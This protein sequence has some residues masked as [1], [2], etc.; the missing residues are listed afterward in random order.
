MGEYKIPLEEV[1]KFLIGHD[2]EKYIVNIEYEH[3]TNLI[4]KFK[5]L[6]DG[7][8]TT[9]TEPLRAFLW[10]KSL[11]ELKEKV[12]F[13]GGNSLTIRN[14]REKYGITI[15]S[16]EHGNHPR[17]ENGY[18]YLLTCDQGYDRMMEFFKK[19]GFYRGLYDKTHGIKDHF[20]ILSPIE[21]YLV[22][23]GKRLFKGYDDYNDIEKFVF[24]LETTGLDPE[25]SRIFAIGCKTN[26]GFE[27]L[28][29][30]EIEGDNADKTEVAAIAKFFTAIDIVKPAIIGGY[31]SANFDWPF[32]F[33]RCEKLGIDIESLAKTRKSDSQIANKDQ[34]LK[35]GNEVENYTQTN[36][37]GYSI[38]DVIHASRKAQAID[39]NMKGVGLKYVCK[40]NKIAK[41]NRVYIKGDK[42]GWY[43]K[44]TNKFYFDNKTGT[45]CETKPAFKYQ[46][47]ITLEDIESNQ[48]NYYVFCVSEKRTNDF[49]IA[50]EVNS[51]GIPIK[52]HDQS[53]Y[54]DDDFDA[55]KKKINRVIKLIINKI[56]AGKTIVLP[57]IFNT[58]VSDALKIRAPKTYSF[59]IT[60]IKALESYINTYIECD[61]KYIVRRYLMDDLWETAEIDNVYNQSSFLLA[62]LIPT[63]FQRVSTMGTAGLWKMIMLTWSYEKNLAIPLPDEKRDFVGGLSRL[64]KVGFSKLLRKADYNSLY[65][66]IQ[67]SSDLFPD[68]DITGVLKSFLKYFHSERF[69][70]KSLAKK[71]KKAGDYQME[72]LYK[73]KQLPLKIFINSLYGALTAPNAFPWAQMDKGEQVTCSARQYLRLMTKFFMGRGYTPT[74]MDSVTFDTPVYIK[75]DD[76]KIDIKA[77]SELFNENSDFLDDE[78]L[79][80]FS[81]KNFKVLTRSGWKEIKYVYRH[82]TDKQI[83][84]LTTKDRYI[85]VTEDHSLFNNGVEVKPIDLEKGSHIDIYN[86]PT[87]SEPNDITPNKAWL[88]GFFLGDGSSNNNIRKKANKYFSKRKKQY[89]YYTTRRYDWKISNKDTTLLTKLQSILKDEFGISANIKDHLKSSGVYNLYTSKKDIGEF[90]S[91]HFYTEYREKKVPL[92]ILNA[93]KEIKKSFIDGFFSADGNGYTLEENTS[94]C[95]KSQVC[96]AGLALILNELGEDFKVMVRP[97]KENIIRFDTGYFRFNAVHKNKPNMSPKKSDEIW[98]K[99]VI[100]NKDKNNYVYDISTEDGT[101]IAGING[102]IAHNTDGINFMA[103]KEGEEHFKYVGKG[104][105]SEVEEGKLYTGIHAV[106]AE[107]NDLYME[108][109]MALGLDGM[110]PSTINLARKNYA[111]LEEDGTISLT[112]NTIKSKKMSAYVE[113]FLD[114]A[115]LLLLNDKGYEFV[116][117]YYSYVDMIY[118]KQIPLSKIATKARVKKT[119]DAYKNRGLNKNGK[120][121]PKQAHMELAIENN[122]H[123]N[124]GDTIYYVNVGTK[125]SHTDVRL[126][127]EGKMLSRLIDNDIIENKPDLLGDYNV[128]RYLAMFNSRIKGLLVVFDPDVRKKILISSP[129]KKIEWL[130]SELDLCNGKPIREKDQDTL[131]ELFTP[132]EMEKKLWEKVGYDPD[133]WFDDNVIFK[134]P[135]ITKEMPV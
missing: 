104:L 18:K 48:Q 131:E 120:S 62:K 56:N 126:D 35:L 101:F 135:G 82:T 68:V 70:A 40:Y 80:D 87:N 134:L 57:S 66:G 61:G 26:K 8:K 16:L 89:N 63:S 7:T 97:D 19:G 2:D 37:F 98:F 22:S 3:K 124:L 41:K 32:I 39:S 28:F 49:E 108:G 121:L 130:K 23:T 67:L 69:T 6:P 14:A 99:R 91:E 92:F 115:F 75:Y 118:N 125:K 96:M 53:F 54:S 77:I 43:W 106:V 29:D 73:R 47:N 11:N 60:S 128:D 119:I 105:N 30:C 64:L 25:T 24:D 58:I 100:K 36:M 31:Y 85:N 44:S 10:M 46:D 72:S 50:N 112:G 107:F 65:P 21:Q 103:P 78:K 59:I 20:V 102:V 15:R 129:S 33:K 83:F 9:E 34:I 13:Y 55:N 79:R 74:V 116:Q 86:I 76:N 133:F 127:K 113:E 84:N 132:S 1:E 109:E 110:W 93:T 122:L 51:I 117:Y 90:F 5:Q 45:Y 38:I 71:Y 27:E 4:Y 111:L 123:V 12:N 17:L 88:M 95:Q 42:I 114:H 52:T 94:F 81:Q